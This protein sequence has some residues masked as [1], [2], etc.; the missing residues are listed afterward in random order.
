MEPPAGQQITLYGPEFEFREKWL[1]WLP[2][3]YAPA[4]EL[5]LRDQ[6]RE[7]EGVDF[8]RFHNK[9]I[10]KSEICINSEIKNKI[11]DDI[12]NIISENI[13]LKLNKNCEKGNFFIKLIGG[14]KI[15]SNG[16]FCFAAFS[17]NDS[18]R[19]ED[20]L[21]SGVSIRVAK[22]G[23]RS[24]GIKELN[25]DNYINRVILFAPDKRNGVDGFSLT[26]DNEKEIEQSWCFIS[27]IITNH[28]YNRLIGECV[29]RSL[30]LFGGD[31]DL[32]DLDSDG[33]IYVKRDVL[34]QLQKMYGRR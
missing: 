31:M 30:G 22:Y 20:L 15:I 11:F 34:A 25:A 26:S 21:K 13:N 29:I 23:S 3:P 24:L 16:I 9:K 4:F 14:R 32:V 10:W 8:G 7:K 2:G 17:C 19:Y 1:N 6:Y 5:D 12:I 18:Y 28:D 33:H 27:P